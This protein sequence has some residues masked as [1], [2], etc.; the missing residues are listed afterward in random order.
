MVAGGFFVSLLIIGH[1]V[2]VFETEELAMTFIEGGL[3]WNHPNYKSTSTKTITKMI[4]L[5]YLNPYNSGS[6][7]KS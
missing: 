1:G 7:T 2:R 3:S 5:S 4:K 6:P